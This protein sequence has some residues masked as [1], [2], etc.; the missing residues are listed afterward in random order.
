MEKKQT[1]GTRF[2][3]N[4]KKNI[5]SR[6]L[7]IAKVSSL[8]KEVQPGTLSDRKIGRVLHRVPLRDKTKTNT[9]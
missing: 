7:L 6:V 8:P 4:S 2:T 1:I 9:P 3:S 5:S